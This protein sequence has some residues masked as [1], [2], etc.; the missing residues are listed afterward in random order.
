MNFADSFRTARWIRIVNLLLQAVLFLTL[1]A[2]LNYIALNHAWRFDLTQNRRHSLSAET[3]SYLE[4]LAQPVRIVATFTGDSDNEELDQAHRDLKGLLRE[5]VYATRHLEG[6]PLVVDFLDIY[7]RRRE[8]ETLG[9][10]Q[11]NVV[12][13]ISGD[14]RRLVTIDELYHLRNKST[15]E[16]FRGESALTAAILDVTSAERKKIYFVQGHGELRPD[17]VGERGLSLLSDALRQRNFELAAL[18]LS[19]TRRVPDDAA[20]LIIPSPRDRFRPFE[21]ELLR[22]YLQTRAGRL[23][24]MLDPEPRTASGLENL[25][26]DWGVWADDNLI[27]DTSANFLSDTGELILKHFLADHPIT[28]S[29]IAN[30]IPVLVGPARVVRD[31]LGRA[32]DDGLNV[33]KLVATSESA[34]GEKNYRNRAVRHSFTPGE[35]LR[36]QLGVVVVSERVRPASLPLSVRGGRLALFGTSDV[37]TNNRLINVGN[38]T[39]FLN[40][41]NWATE[42]NVDI[43]IAP[44]A[45]ERFQLTLSQEEL[46]R[47]RL[48]LLFVVPG[49]V[50][51]L[52]LFVYWTRR[53]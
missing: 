26:F 9:I 2:G 19:Q 47:L 12:V 24:L 27:L 23:I 37:V 1:F 28:R 29:L 50:G 14:R 53:S 49:I 10:E 48:G 5:Y 21:E 16:A 38:L 31:D 44:R 36:G 32:L 8:A 25:L 22:N 20:L 11:P 33:K 6:G 52:G 30:D 13:V 3:K 35:D 7:Q 43:N 39:L 51:L 17:D 18:D 45:I 40:T 15:R 42:R 41:V 34:W 46:S 4:N